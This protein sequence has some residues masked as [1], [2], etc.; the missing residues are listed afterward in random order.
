MKTPSQDSIVTQP[1]QAWTGL[2]EPNDDAVLEPDDFDSDVATLLF[3][4]V[5]Q[6]LPEERIWMTNLDDIGARE[7]WLPTV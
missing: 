7:G 2:Y 6:M 5:L 1:W 4:T 3:K